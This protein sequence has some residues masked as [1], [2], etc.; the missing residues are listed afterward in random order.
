MFEAGSVFL[1]EW[2]DG[3]IRANGGFESNFLGKSNEALA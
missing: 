3:L 1:G 2:L